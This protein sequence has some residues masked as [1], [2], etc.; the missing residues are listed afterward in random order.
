LGFGLE[1]ADTEISFSGSWKLLG[2][3]LELIFGLLEITHHARSIDWALIVL[4]RIQLILP[5]KKKTIFQNHNSDALH[6]E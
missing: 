2:L 6:D 1:L 3:G 5:N 4:N